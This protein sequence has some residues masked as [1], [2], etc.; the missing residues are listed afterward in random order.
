MIKAWMMKSSIYISNADICDENMA[1][2]TDWTDID[3]GTGDSS[4]ATFDSKSTMKLN[5]GANAISLAARQRDIG[6]CGTRTVISLSIYCDAIGTKDNTDGAFLLAWD[7]SNRFTATFCSDGLFIY[8]WPTGNEVGTDLVVQDAWQEWTFD[9]N[10][11]AKTVDVYLDN[12]LKASGFSWSEANTDN[13]NGTIVLRQY[14]QVTA[15]MLSYID[16]FKAGSNFA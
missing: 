1:D 3:S 5:S 9:I 13:P 15:N 11:T 6:S 2:I 16:W 14:G 12:V 7:G 4:Q 10:W 8:T